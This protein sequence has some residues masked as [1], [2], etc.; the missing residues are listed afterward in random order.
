[1]SQEKSR[2]LLDPHSIRFRKPLIHRHGF[3][4]APEQFCLPIKIVFMNV[5]T[6]LPLFCYAFAAREVPERL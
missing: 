4:A 6:P 1:M 2:R 3:D 5:W